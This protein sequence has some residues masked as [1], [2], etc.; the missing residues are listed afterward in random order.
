MGQVLDLKSFPQITGGCPGYHGQVAVCTL[1]PDAA[2]FVHCASTLGSFEAGA[3]VGERWTVGPWGHSGAARLLECPSYFGMMPDSS[4]TRS[5][6][7]A[8]GRDRMEIRL[9]AGRPTLSQ[10]EAI[11]RQLCSRLGASR[12]GRM[13]TY[14]K[15]QHVGR[16][17][18]GQLA[19]VARVLVWWPGQGSY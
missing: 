14:C 15:L 13:R 1:T 4:Q 2:Q 5:K 10:R 6:L 12:R 3:L 18:W 19:C 8:A 9:C 7:G 17:A 16:E 11:P